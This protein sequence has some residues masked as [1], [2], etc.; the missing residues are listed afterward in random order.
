MAAL[1]SHLSAWTY[2]RMIA[3]AARAHGCQA[4]IDGD[5]EGPVVHVFVPTMDDHSG[6]T[7]EV[8]HTVRSMEGLAIILGI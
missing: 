2:A 4:Q 7:Y 1:T 3:T 8:L 5:I 6:R